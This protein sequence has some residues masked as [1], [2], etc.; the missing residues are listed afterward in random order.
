[1]IVFSVA[2]GSLN[3]TNNASPSILTEL[4]S[5]IGIFEIPAGRLLIWVPTKLVTSAQ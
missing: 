5:V 2:A 4:H 1:M 3:I